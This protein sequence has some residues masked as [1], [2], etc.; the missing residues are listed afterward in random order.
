MELVAPYFPNE[1][2]SFS[3]IVRSYLINVCRTVV[4]VPCLLQYVPLV[5]LS[6]ENIDQL[7]QYANANYAKL[8][9]SEMRTRE[10]SHVLCVCSQ[11]VIAILKLA[12]NLDY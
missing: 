8:H 1:I 10:R 6:E 11:L 4:A 9:K 12:T 5:F 2:E 7:A 3:N